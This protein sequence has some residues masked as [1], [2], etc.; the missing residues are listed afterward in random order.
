[1]VATKGR[2]GRGKIR[3]Q[4]LCNISLKVIERP[5]VEGAIIRSRNNI[6]KKMRGQ[7]SHHQCKQQKVRPTQFAQGTEISFTSG[8]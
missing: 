5:N 4:P 3:K 6:S 8:S 1:M 7:W 2:T